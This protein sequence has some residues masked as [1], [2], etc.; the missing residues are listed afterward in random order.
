[1]QSGL[2]L[3]NLVLVLLMGLA[4]ACL[5]GALLFLYRWLVRRRLFPQ[6]PRIWGVDRLRFIIFGSIS[7][8]LGA[9]W[10]VLAVTS[11]PAPAPPGPIPGAPAPAVAARPPAKTAAPAPAQ[12]KEEGETYFP[13]PHRSPA[14]G[15]E[16]A[17]PPNP[18]RDLPAPTATAQAPAAQPG[19]AQSGAP[20]GGQAEVPAWATVT[21]L[22]SASTQSTSQTF[23]TTTSVTTLTTAAPTTEPPT[24]A[25]PTTTAPTTLSTEST[26]S[27]TVAPPAPPELTVKAAPVPARGQITP[28]QPDQADQPARP[29]KAAKPA[30]PAKPAAEAGEGGDY[31]ACLGSY[32][33]QGPA[34]AHVAKLAAQGVKAEAVAVE[35]GAKGRWWRVYAGRFPD[36][37]AAAA[38]AKAW[39]KA[40]LAT[41]PF[42]VRRR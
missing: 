5:A 37:A 35:L 12:T 41:T 6:L 28:D 24:T 36:A 32:K 1:M 40:G 13:L 33:E 2:N 14:G 8:V 16:R 18:N 25:A 38:Q 19:G 23:A 7:F 15:E 26:T 3:L 21:S 22:T 27:T 11:Q 4:G 42:P 39:E 20:A 30:K 31:T 9:A 10:L 34:K 17:M 29:A